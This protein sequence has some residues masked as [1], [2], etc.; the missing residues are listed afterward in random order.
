VLLGITLLY[1]AAKCT[2]N[3]RD[4]RDCITVGVSVADPESSA[5]MPIDSRCVPNFVPPRATT[6]VRLPTTLASVELP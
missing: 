6:I 5:P 4:L 2:D 1:V 3:P